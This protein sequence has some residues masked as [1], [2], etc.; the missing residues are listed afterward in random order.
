MTVGF[1]SEFHKM[2]Q[3]IKYQ[4]KNQKSFQAFCDAVELCCGPEAGR[5][6][7]GYLSEAIGDGNGER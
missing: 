4:T 5:R 3:V 2:S 7:R 1:S 6:Q